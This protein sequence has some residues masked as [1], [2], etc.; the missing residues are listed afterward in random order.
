MDISRVEIILI[1]G[2]M[3]LALRALPQILFL[4][5]TFPEAWDRFLRYLS[6]SLI[7]SIIA[8]TLFS[9]GARFE[10]QA[11]PYRAVALSAAIVI[12]H[13]TRSPVTGMVIGTV[14]VTLL[15]WLR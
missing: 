15:S 11:A 2:L 1:M 12:A 13:Q 7:C 10:A 9:S 5:K 4:G 14:L 8:I 6:Y 3:A